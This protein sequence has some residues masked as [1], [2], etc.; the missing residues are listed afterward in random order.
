MCAD[1]N[2][3]VALTHT[4]IN[5]HEDNRHFYKYKKTC[6]LSGDIKQFYTKIACSGPP[7]VQPSDVGAEAEWILK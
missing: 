5:C 2:F 4:D 1:I 6:T 3:C 7:C